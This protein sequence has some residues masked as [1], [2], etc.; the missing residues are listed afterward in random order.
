M[1]STDKSPDK[2]TEWRFSLDDLGGE[3]EP[4]GDDSSTGGN[5]AGSVST[6]ESLEPQ[7]IDPTNAVFFL[8][9]SL[10]TVLFI[11]LALTGL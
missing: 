7:Q 9:G 6:R 11:V 8:I 2:E 1:S 4:A 10:G 5:V 3:G